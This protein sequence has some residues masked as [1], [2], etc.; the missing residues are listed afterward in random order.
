MRPITTNEVAWSV[1]V[2][3][4]VCLLIMFVNPAKTAEPIKV[5]I[6]WAEGTMY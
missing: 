3:L 5:L 6:G 2:C 1:S 4:A